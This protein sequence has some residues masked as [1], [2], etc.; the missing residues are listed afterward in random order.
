M[1]QRNESMGIA[2]KRYEKYANFRRN[3][4]ILRSLKGDTCAEVSVATKIKTGNRV[5]M[6]EH[7][8]I[9]PDDWEVKA[10]AHYFEVPLK[11][12]LEQRIEVTISFK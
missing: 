11:E 12:F 9:F 1:I 8:R 3:L 5:Q 6:F 7:G 10:L 2:L 4:S